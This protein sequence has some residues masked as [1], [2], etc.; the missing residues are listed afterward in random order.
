MFLNIISYLHRLFVKIIVV[1]FI[2]WSSIPTIVRVSR[3]L[4]HYFTGKWVPIH[5]S[6]IHPKTLSLIKHKYTF[7][8]LFFI[9]YVIKTIDLKKKSFKQWIPI[10]NTIPI[11]GV[12]KWNYS[13]SK[14]FLDDLHHFTPIVV[15][16]C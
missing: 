2:K 11:S 7:R 15:C 1:F 5:K 13:K 10:P 14:C 9:S 8:I 4:N 6:P 12:E 3:Y 16:T